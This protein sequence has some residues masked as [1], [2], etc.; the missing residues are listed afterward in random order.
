MARFSWNPSSAVS[1]TSLKLLHVTFPTSSATSPTPIEL[2]TTN[3]CDGITLIAHF[4]GNPL[5]EKFKVTLKPISLT[6]LSIVSGLAPPMQKCSSFIDLCDDV[7]LVTPEIN[8]EYSKT[9]WNHHCTATNSHK[10]MYTI[11]VIEYQ[12]LIKYQT[13]NILK[14]NFSNNQLTKEFKI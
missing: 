6:T 11:N 13:S 3:M 4:T 2:E 7:K 1:N 9:H 8:L 12:G 10:L 14:L 5:N